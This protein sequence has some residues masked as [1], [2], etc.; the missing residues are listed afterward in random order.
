MWK[1]INTRPGYYSSPWYPQKGRVFFH[2]HRK[3]I[4]E[5][6]HLR[7]ASALLASGNKLKETNLTDWLQRNICTFWLEKSYERVFYSWWWL[8][9]LVRGNKPCDWARYQ[10]HAAVSQ[11]GRESVK[12]GGGL[13]PSQCWGV[14]LCVRYSGCKDTWGEALSSG[15]HSQCT[16]RHHASSKWASTYFSDYLNDF[17]QEAISAAALKLQLEVPVRPWHS[18]RL[19]W[20][21]SFN[22]FLK[23]LSWYKSVNLLKFVLNEWTAISLRN[24]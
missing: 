13:N 9:L 10:R 16:F 11:R 5:Q 2:N 24:H 23:Q 15:C 21:P 7:L 6:N 17:H 8:G 12:R 3:G 20:E 22:G 14:D 1:T 19:W 4:R 18:C